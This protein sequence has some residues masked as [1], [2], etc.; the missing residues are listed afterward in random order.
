MD[1]TKRKTLQNSITL[2]LCDAWHGE[3]RLPCCAGFSLADQDSL[4][5]PRGES[6]LPRIIFRFVRGL[7]YSGFGKS[8]G[9]PPDPSLL[10]STSYM[11]IGPTSIATRHTSSLKCLPAENLCT[12]SMTS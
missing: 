12:S 8:H 11:L 7:C 9:A 6:S 10:R 5:R 4:S 1:A 3:H 2:V